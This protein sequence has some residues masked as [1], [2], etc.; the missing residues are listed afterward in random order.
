VK[1]A[2]CKAALLPALALAVAGVASAQSLQRVTVTAFSLSADT[3][4]PRVGAPFRLMV[5]LRLRESVKAVENLQ[6]P[7]L[8]GF[9]LLGDVR[10]TSAG[11]HGTVY[12][13][14]IELAP[15]NGG[16]QVIPPA[17]F[18]AVDARDGKAKQYST[19]ALT[20]RV[21]GAPRT[22]S[23]LLVSKILISLGI[24]M[25]VLGVVLAL[26]LSRRR[27]APAMP[28]PE[29][30][31]PAAPPACVDPIAEARALLERDPT[32]RGALQARSV[33]WRMVGASDGETLAD[34]MDRVRHAHPRLAT[35]LP[36]LEQAAF[37]HDGDVTAS[38]ERAISALR[39]LA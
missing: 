23:P 39:R 1:R 9:Q 24:A 7:V 28:Q 38:I 8:A 6:L 11:A 37:T 17:T 36:P 22:I 19:N 25:M 32:R 2:F 33:V 3:L 12:R 10:G 27:A 18:D 16:T 15:R 30:E 20:L 26:L 35:L 13:E 34:V 5:T 31:P 29:P 4:A 14:S 21:A